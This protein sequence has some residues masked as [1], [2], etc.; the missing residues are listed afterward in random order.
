[1]GVGGGFGLSIKYMLA[2]SA[3]TEKTRL[4]PS[5][6]GGRDGDGRKKGGE[7]EY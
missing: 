6:Q 5:I 4:L 7:G 1:M 3:N 2:E